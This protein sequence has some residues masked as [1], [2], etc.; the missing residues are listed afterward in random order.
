MRTPLPGPDYSAY[1]THKPRDERGHDDNHE[2]E[3][4]PVSDVHGPNPTMEIVNSDEFLDSI[5][6]RVTEGGDVNVD[7]MHL[8]LD[9]GRVLIISGVVFVGRLV[10]ETLQ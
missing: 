10:K 7:G 6:G 9:D 1:P 3:N 8:L 5:R 4:H 2:L